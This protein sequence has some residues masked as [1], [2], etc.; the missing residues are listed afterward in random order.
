MKCCSRSTRIILLLLMSFLLL[1]G[2][3][4]QVH[5]KEYRIL[6][7]ADADVSIKYP[8]TSD[9]GLSLTEYPFFQ[10]KTNIILIGGMR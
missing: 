9:R 7:S 6:A 10:G 1:L 8:D 2:L 5:A 3:A 4:A